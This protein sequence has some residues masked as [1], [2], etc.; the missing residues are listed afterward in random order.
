[1]T[2]K[3]FVA[4]FVAL[5]AAGTATAGQPAASRRGDLAGAWSVQVTLRDCTTNAPAGAPFNS[6]VSFHKG[7]TL[8]EDAGTLAFAPGQR[9]GG[10][11]KWSR[12]GNRTYRQEMVNLILFDNP[13]NLPPGHNPNLPITP[14]F[15]AGWQVVT[16]TVV[17][18]GDELSSSGTN[19]FYRSN[20]EVYR[21][22]C[23]T[24]TGRRIE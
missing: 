11:G 21:T 17:V 4:G 5:A 13:P 2:W 22:G 1:M 16:H 15:F 19:A 8:T 23:S 20:G 6:L 18:N 9:T 24:A 3:P 7:G 14:G 10:H 12:L